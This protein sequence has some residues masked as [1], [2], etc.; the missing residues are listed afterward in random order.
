MSKAEKIE[1]IIICPNCAIGLKPADAGLT[2]P[3]C[4]LNYK[5]DQN[6]IFL[7]A[8]QGYSPELTDE[9]IFKIKLFFK[10]FP[11]CYKLLCYFFGAPIVGE[12]PNKFLKSFTAD[13][14]L[15]NIGSGPKVI[16]DDVI[17]LDIYP[18]QNVDLVANASVLPIKSACVDAIIC[19]SLIEHLENPSALVAELHRVLKP[20]GKVYLVAPFILSFH[21]SPNDF[22]R[23]T[24][25]GLSALFAHAGFSAIS[26]KPLY[27][28][29]SSLVNILSEWLAILFSFNSQH[30]HNFCYLFFYT[31]L[32]PIKFLDFILVKFESAKNSALGFSITAAK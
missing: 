1:Q 17:N 9:A 31:I 15:L 18:F 2:C 19:E 10:K 32:S 29:T 4:N 14:V 12:S 21:S 3:N 25:Q 20:G 23:W 7:T 6:K 24:D 5:R 28:P 26:V 27:G 13:S 16:R 11:H 22:Y 8:N 30:I